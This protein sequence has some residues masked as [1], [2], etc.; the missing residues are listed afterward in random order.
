M[1]TNSEFSI[2]GRPIGNGHKTYII[3]E[4]SAN[5]GQ[6]FDR[7][8]SLVRFAKEAGADAVKLQTYTADTLTID[9][10]QDHFRIQQNTIWDG[11]RLY[12]LYHEAHTPWEWQPKLKKIAN[13]LGLDL[14]ASPFDDS[15]VDFLETLDV[16]AY[17]VASFEIVDTGLLKRIAATGKPVI[18][19]TGM[20]TV[21]EIER[22]INTLRDHGCPQIALLKC[23]SAYPAP[24]ESMNLRTIP[25]LVLRFGLPVGL[26]D[27]TLTHE[28]AIASVAL[29]GCI[30][31]K[32]L[33]ASR[34]DGGPDGSFSLEPAEFAE[35][36]KSVRNTE[37]ALGRARYG[38]TSSDAANRSFRR[39]LFVVKNVNRGEAFTSDNIRSIRPGQGLEPRFMDDVIGKTATEDIE[40]GTPLN[41][42]H[43]A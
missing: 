12:D 38:P 40:R 17:K 39:S 10:D 13:D 42:K 8:C 43:V 22:A 36:V 35:M 9:C 4:L 25:D 1:K 28:S 14:F 23:T 27:H 41:W 2:N 34:A 15:A 26:S 31:E 37:L 18:V 11:Q 3:A 32:H 30:I 16:P 5:H 29:G 33:T 21:E 7:A 24:P 6:S 20:S 19:S